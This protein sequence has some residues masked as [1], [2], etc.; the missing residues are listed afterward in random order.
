[1][2][3]A[4][5]GV[6]LI[7]LLAATPSAYADEAFDNQVKE[8]IAYFK[9]NAKRAKDPQ[10]WGDLVM[11]LGASEHP[12][13][14]E[15]MGRLLLKDKDV[16]HQMI[17]ASALATFKGSDDS[18]DAAGKALLMV[19]EKGKKLE[20]DVIDSVAD[21]L[22]KLQYKPAVFA[23]CEILRKGADPYLQVTV[24][25]AVGRLDDKRALPTLLEL[26]ERLPVGYSWETGE[27]TVDT[28]ASGTA[29]QDAA[30]A[31]WN[32]KYG[33]MMKA[34]ASPKVMLK[35]YIQELAKAVARICGEKIGQAADLRLWMEEHAK[36]LKE[37]GI[38]VP[39]YKGPR[40]KKT[41]EE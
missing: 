41:D 21:S 29:D 7:G 39:K 22:G 19:L 13:A 35:I 11:E 26:W 2:K 38:E 16:D 1:M 9:K 36:E 12:K 8:Q 20:I 40:R 23:L 27:V 3:R 31:A 18:R 4:I 5:L 17:L 10:V 6:A 30:E 33:G 37:L 32:A 14:A 15:Y 34:K 25:R 28:G 24:V